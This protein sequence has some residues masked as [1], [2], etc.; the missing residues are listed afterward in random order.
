VTH[1]IAARSSLKVLAVGLAATACAAAG[2][3]LG[4]LRDHGGA[5]VDVAH[6]SARRFVAGLAHDHLQRHV[7]VAEVRRGGVAQLM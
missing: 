7:P 3:E 6:R 2:E 5:W 1:T 4:D